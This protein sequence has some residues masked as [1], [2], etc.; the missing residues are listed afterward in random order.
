MIASRLGPWLAPIGPAFFIGRAIFHQ[1][2]APLWVAVLMGTAV[3]LVGIAATHTAL[4]AWAWNEA[5]R[6]SD[7]VAPFKLLV[8][9]SLVYFVSAAILSVM[10][11]VWP[12]LVAPYAPGVYLS[13]AGVAYVTLAAGVKLGQWESDRDER[14]SQSKTKNALGI[15]VKR[16]R[17]R[18]KALQESVKSLTDDL[19]R[20][21]QEKA[22]LVNEID[23]LGQK[24]DRASAN[25]QGDGFIPGD[26]AALEQANESRTLNIEERRD[27][28]LVLKEQDKTNAE[29]A[30]MLGVSPKTVGRDLKALNGKV[31]QT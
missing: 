17:E 19:D 22:K 9:L 26:K 21:T 25:V 27:Q 29:I 23:K 13:L 3:E 4:K 15:E 28:V 31:R 11:E 8:F 2:A 14:L 6:K 18:H 30:A 5:R 24:R 10:L 1:L 20:L 12:S 16:L 7:P